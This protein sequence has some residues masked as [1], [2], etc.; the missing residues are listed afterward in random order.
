[1]VSGP[2]GS[3]HA[4]GWVSNPVIVS[5]K[6]DPNKIRVN[7]DTRNMAA[8]VQKTHF[9]I[10][11]SSQ[12]RHSFRGSDRFS[13]LD[14]NHAFHQFPMDEESRK[15]FFFLRTALTPFRMPDLNSSGMPVIYCT[16]MLKDLFSGMRKYL[17]C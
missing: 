15:R 6:W 3:E 7:L 16:G 5:K 14:M 1:M 2:L 12:L 8:A 10:P 11:T 17:E 4:R 13:V 9:P